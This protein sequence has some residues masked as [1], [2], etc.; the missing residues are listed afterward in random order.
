MKYDIAEE[1]IIL[2]YD[3]NN[4]DQFQGIEHA[5]LRELIDNGVAIAN[6]NSVIISASDVLNLD[7][8]SLNVLDFPIYFPNSIH[9]TTDDLL[10]D[11]ALNI[12]IRYL[13]HYPNG[14]ILNI[15]RVGC[16]I[17]HNDQVYLLNQNQYQIIQKV[18]LLNNKQ[19]KS[20]VSNLI[21]LHEIKKIRT[22]SD[23]I[24]LDEYLE[25]E[26]IIVPDSIKVEAKYENGKLRIIPK[27]TNESLTLEDE[28]FSD[29]FKKDQSI[30]STY[31]IEDKDGERIRIIPTQEIKSDLETL[32]SVNELE[33]D[34]A[35]E[36]LLENPENFLSGEALDISF[37]YSDRVKEI[38]FYKPRYTSFV[39]K[40]KSQWIP[41]FIIKDRIDGDSNVVIKDEKDL[42]ILEQKISQAVSSG[43]KFIDV[44]GKQVDTA[45]AKDFAKLASMQLNED[46]PID[47]KLVNN[48]PKVLI[49]KDNQFTLEYQENLKNQFEIS[50]VFYGV[51]NLRSHILLKDHQKEGIAWLQNMYDCEQP[52]CLLA[53]DMGLGKT[54]QMLYFIEWIASKR[55]GNNP[56]LICA[57]VSLLANWNNEYKNFFEQHSYKILTFAG[58]TARRYFK[59][60]NPE[61]NKEDAERLQK[62]HII[63]TSYE[64]L[65]GYQCCFGLVE[66]DVVILDEAQKIKTNGTQ[67]TQACKALKS[68]FK[69]A[70]SGTPVENSLMDIWSIIDFC[71]SGL[72]DT[73]KN[74]YKKYHKSIADASE[75]EQKNITEQLRSEIGIYIK[76]RLKI[77]VAKDLPTKHDNKN[78]RRE[79]AMSDY[80]FELYKQEIDIIKSSNAV[81]NNMLVTINN[82]KGISDHP[83]YLAGIDYTQPLEILI[84]RSSKLVE[85]V[86]LL[87]A[88]KKLEEK[89]IIFAERKEIQRLLNAVVL[90]KFAIDPSII[91]GD[92]PTQDTNS[93]VM[94]SR[95]AAINK[96]QRNEGFNVIIM[97]PVAAGVGLNVV[98]ANHVIHYS[99]HWNPAKE[100]QATDRAYRIGQTKEV[101]VYYPLAVFPDSHRIVDGEIQFSFD[102][103]LDL[104][105]QRKQQLAQNTLFPTD[106]AEIILDDLFSTILKN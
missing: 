93:K 19:T 17:W 52:G 84:Q 59:G 46:K 75:I 8:N 18:E 32:K 38:G 74:F 50:H 5:I 20:L 2:H 34:K 54:L 43:D 21:D 30:K 99:R 45:Y 49:I 91:N 48:R 90:S 76:R 85:T 105:L 87:D 67:I 56:I 27:I 77:D 51:D 89:V 102:E 83:D 71:A 100:N 42:Q 88:I 82:L 40:Y 29:K 6:N 79:V 15:R 11:K 39:S 72:L 55:S 64:T 101:F 70:M 7:R 62:K 78:S 69:I 16:F 36:E 94:L 61:L 26:N 41:G 60:Y 37:F 104:L 81:K 103:T 57:P 73:E 25:N 68:N 3:V 92:T 33:D 63:L 4:I 95:Q 22:K 96:F 24:F 9:L 86:K 98:G 97:S 58:D 31:S 1:G 12:S 106:Q 35:I 80:Q 14:E 23:N 13:K 53:D 28:R 65:R 66:F 10:S 47:E 44:E